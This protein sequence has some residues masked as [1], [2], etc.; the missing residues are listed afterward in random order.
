MENGTNE[1]APIA[2]KIG[3]DKE[4]ESLQ[5]IIKLTKNS[6]F[7]L[8][9]L[10]MMAEMMLSEKNRTAYP[11]EY[12]QLKAGMKELHTSI[13]TCKNELDKTLLKIG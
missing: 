6:I 1:T 13:T 12:Y 5:S 2:N 10:P 7:P 8:A 3:T 4:L 11:D 9:I